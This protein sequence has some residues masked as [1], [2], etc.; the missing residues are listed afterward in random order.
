MKKF[1][2]FSKKKCLYTSRS[3]IKTKVTIKFL[4][5]KKKKKR[6]KKN[7]RPE[8]KEKKKKTFGRKSKKKNFRPEIDLALTGLTRLHVLCGRISFKIQ[9][10]TSKAFF[11]RIDS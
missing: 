9:S 11:L 6:K 2:S 1:N 4:K 7:F 8:I 10:V 3:C 5:K